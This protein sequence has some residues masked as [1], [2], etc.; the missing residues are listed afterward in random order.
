L[1]TTSIVVL[2]VIVYQ[3]YTLTINGLHLLLIAVLS[4][5]YY[6]LLSYVTERTLNYGIYSLIKQ[7]FA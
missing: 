6:L 1:F 4:L 7:M 5:S 2:S 3:N